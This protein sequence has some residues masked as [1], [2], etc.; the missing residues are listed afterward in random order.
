MNRRI[1]VFTRSKVVKAIGCAFLAC[2]LGACSGPAEKAGSDERVAASAQAE[3]GS[4]GEH[5]NMEGSHGDHGNMEGSHGDHGNM[6]GS[7]AAAKDSDKPAKAA[8]KPFTITGEA[9]DWDAPDSI[10]AVPA[11]DTATLDGR[12]AAR[13]NY[14]DNDEMEKV[15]KIDPAEVAKEPDPDVWL[16][17]FVLKQEVREYPFP[18]TIY[19][20]Q[21]ADYYSRR[22]KMQS[23]LAERAQAIP[24]EDRLEIERTH[25]WLLLYL[26]DF[27]AV[28]D[29]FGPDGK[30]SD[31][32]EDGS[33]AFTVAQSLYRLGRYKESLTYAK[34]AY[35]RLPNAVL[36]TRW[37][38]MLS[39]LG[40][41]GRTYLDQPDHGIYTKKHISGIF[42]HRDWEKFPFEDVTEDF[43]I[44]RWGG[45]GSVS[46]VDLDQDGWDDL[47]WE[48][49]FWHPEVYRNLEG[50]GFEAIPRDSLNSDL[51]SPIM[52]TPADYNND[53][54]PDLFRH[55]CNYDGPGPHQ[56]LRN[57]GDMKFEDTTEESLLGRERGAGMIIAWG[58]Y[59]LD[60]FLD[61]LLADSWGPSRLYRNKGDGTFEN[62]TKA[63][64]LNTPRTVG[65]SF[66]DYNDDGWPDVW[67]LG[68]DSKLLFRNNGDGTF[69]DVTAKVG[70][71]DITGKKGYISFFFD[72]NNDGH[73]DLFTGQYVVSSD[74]RWGFGPVC[75]CSNLLAEEGYS[76][77]E[78]KFA[79]TIYKNNGDGT[80]ENIYKKS[81]FI[82]LGM[83]GSNH[84]DW[85][86]DGYED[87]LMG[88]GGP[89]FQ[90]AEPFLFYE[91]NGGDGT[92]DL[93]TPYE[94]LG[95]W[96]KGHGSAFADFNHDG[97]LDV[98]TNNGGAA[99]GDIWPSLVLRNKGNCNHW[100]QIRLLANEPGTNS[101][102]VGARVT[103]ETDDMTLVKEVQAGGQFGATNSFDLHFGLAQ[104]DKVRKITVRWP[105]RAHST[106]EF[107]DIDVDQNITIRQGSGKIE[108]NW[109]SPVPACGRVAGETNPTG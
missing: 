72:Y 86:N 12:V 15:L 42:P 21:K 5:G 65:L 31:R 63:A 91:N 27:Q 30:Y 83:M 35:E 8:S 56:L 34:R 90:Q 51:A 79:T 68:W 95:L 32:N 26:G 71:D 14:F 52:F 44:K 38:M 55:C 60:G 97:F 57:L 43:N 87:L 103:V 62:T 100:L 50:K 47:V 20:I 40:Y 109:S 104:A 107:S 2:S 16:V 92:F 81:K 108:S 1:D 19:F 66:G 82:P 53:G 89:F 22:E 74:E 67:A 99:P 11:V 80:F 48:R 18:I 3:K 41:Y 59:D 9:F 6:E 58:D 7:H 88:A 25:A 61:L 102:A 39:E 64:G 105:N 46:F 73:I 85:N 101:F 17:D 10:G 13:H 96:G 54:L 75:T 33:I 23:I 29:L 98:A 37:Q 49:K 36:D 28:V 4:Q 93:I 69:E 106:V 77:R 94:M 24:A 78:W 76:E 70:I 45:T 84:G